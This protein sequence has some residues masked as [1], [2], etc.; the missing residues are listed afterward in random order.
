[1]EDPPPDQEG[2]DRRDMNHR[3]IEPDA[4][5]ALDTLDHQ[6]ERADAVGA[7]LDIAIGGDGAAGSSSRRS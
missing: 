6:T 3:R 4:G 2:R 7:G 1:M 5:A